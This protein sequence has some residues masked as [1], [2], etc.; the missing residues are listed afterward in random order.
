MML[1]RSCQGA[2]RC[3]SEKYV[4]LHTN[5]VLGMAALSIFGQLILLPIAAALILINRAIH[6]DGLMRQSNRMVLKII[7]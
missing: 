2:S 5:D 3:A 4:R 6:G 1:R 7:R